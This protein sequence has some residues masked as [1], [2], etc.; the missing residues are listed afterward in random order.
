M[1][2]HDARKKEKKIATI[3]VNKG[4]LEWQCDNDVN[5]IKKKKK[6]LLKKVPSDISLYQQFSWGSES[7]G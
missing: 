5:L 2:Y 3:H 1:Q 7:P 4:N 6:V